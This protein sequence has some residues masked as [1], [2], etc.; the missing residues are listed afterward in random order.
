[1]SS[2]PARLAVKKSP[3]SEALRSLGQALVLHWPEYTIEAAG[4]GVF[5]ISA[6]LFGTWLSHPA[7]ALNQALPDPLQRRVVMGLVMGL[8][9][10]AIIYSRWGKR[11][12]AHI[13]PAV[14][15]AF[16]RLGKVDPRDAFFYVLAQFLG[17]LGG[18][19][20]SAAILGDALAHPAVVYVTTRPGAGGAVSAFGG[21]LAISF[22][23]LLAVLV[24]SNSLRWA[25]YTGLIAGALVASY[26]AL[27]EPLSGMSM[28]PARTFAS[29]APAGVWTGLWVYFLAPP[30]GMLAAAELYRWIR[31]AEPVWCA[32]YRHPSHQE[33]TDCIFRCNYPGCGS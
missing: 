13:N 15:L 4:L 19:L 2:T 22:L 10:I 33:S 6:C 3:P 23:L 29:A 7:S 17:G 28:N 30:L 26:I 1:M 21:E 5:M 11:S 14:T 27:E 8:T 25:R 24:S 16:L 31:R 20:I 9:A 18:V 12:G 32:K